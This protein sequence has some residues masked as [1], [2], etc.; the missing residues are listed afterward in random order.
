MAGISIS[1]RLC[2][3]WN[4]VLDIDVGDVMDK[5]EIHLEEWHRITDVGERKKAMARALKKFLS[6][7]EAGEDNNDS[8][9]E[10]RDTL[11]DKIEKALKASKQE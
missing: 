11:S 8:G 10:D 9:F 1:C 6:N 2:G 4:I 5:Y 3:D 7:N